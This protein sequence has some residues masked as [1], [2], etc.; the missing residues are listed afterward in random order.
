MAVYIKKTTQI[1]FFK[2]SKNLNLTWRWFETQTPHKHKG[3][4]SGG[5]WLRFLVCGLEWNTPFH[6]LLLHYTVRKY[7]SP[8]GSVG[9]GLRLCFGVAVAL[10]LAQGCP[11][12]R[13][14]PA[15]ALPLCQTV[16]MELNSV[17]RHTRMELFSQLV[18]P[19]TSCQRKG[20]FPL[21]F[22]LW[23]KHLFPTSCYC[24]ATEETERKKWVSAVW[25]TLCPLRKRSSCCWN[26][27]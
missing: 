23:Q 9:N 3:Q 27:K 5:L 15:T 21:T 18:P 10:Y 7:A 13:L 2:K 8:G 16:L 19:L 24:P 17:K 4:S 26:K 14:K 20:L 25:L 1:A 11:L 22:C 12:L 6:L